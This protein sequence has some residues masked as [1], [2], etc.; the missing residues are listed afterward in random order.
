MQPEGWS[1][2]VA[3]PCRPSSQQR[4]LALAGQPVAMSML[5]CAADDHLFAVATADVA[6]ALRVVPAL[7]ALNAAAQA[8]LGGRLLGQR[9]AAVPGMT[10]NPAALHSQLAGQRPDGQPLA[11]QVLV[12]AHG[13]RVFQA[14]VIGPQAD[15]A[16]A[17]P[18]FESI[19]VLP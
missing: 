12:F 14:T 11:E 19:R 3:L 7:Q 13:T 10:P 2:S 4:N 8:N 17:Q 9:A 18:F 15:D 1:L 6:D 16:R 5:S